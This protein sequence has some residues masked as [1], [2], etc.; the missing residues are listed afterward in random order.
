MPEPIPYHPARRL[1]FVTLGETVVAFGHNFSGRVLVSL[2]GGEQYTVD[3]GD[4]K[5]H[6]IPGHHHHHQEMMP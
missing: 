6:V 2:H 3:V 5:T 4:G 1:T